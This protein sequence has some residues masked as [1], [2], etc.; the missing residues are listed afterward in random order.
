[1]DKKEEETIVGLIKKYNEILLHSMR[2]AVSEDLVN[3]IISNRDDVNFELKDFVNK[4]EEFKQFV[5]TEFFRLN[6][7]S[8]LS[9]LS[10]MEDPFIPQKRGS[11]NLTIQIPHVEPNNE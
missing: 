9:E 3:L 6:S 5:M 4:K 11:G 8:V 7:S 10:K 1:M 2:I